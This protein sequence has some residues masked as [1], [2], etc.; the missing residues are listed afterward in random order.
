MMLRMPRIEKS[1]TAV[2]PFF[3]ASPVAAATFVV[4]VLTA[5]LAFV[6]PDLVAVE[7]LVA[8]FL[9]A[10]LALPKATDIR[11]G[12]FGGGGSFGVAG[13]AGA[14]ALRP[15][16]ASEKRFFACSWACSCSS[17]MASSRADLRWRGDGWSA[18]STGAESRLDGDS[19]LAARPKLGAEKRR[20]VAGLPDVDDVP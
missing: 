8:D 14:D 16:K 15:Q 5:L 6:T 13:A 20:S 12:P 17:G 19:R 7:A 4:D 11:L 2:P 1:L 10:V 3:T 18:P 9:A